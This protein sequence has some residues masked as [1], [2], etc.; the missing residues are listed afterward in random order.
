MLNIFVHAAISSI[1]KLIFT[2]V[3]LVLQICLALAAWHYFGDDILGAFSGLKSSLDSLPFIGRLTSDISPDLIK[4]NWED[5][6][7]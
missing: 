2:N 1:V 5:Y 3:T 6:G 4:P 7:L